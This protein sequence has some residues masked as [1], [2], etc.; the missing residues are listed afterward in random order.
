[1]SI[2]I[3]VLPSTKLLK[4]CYGSTQFHAWNYMLPYDSIHENSLKLLYV[5]VR[6]HARNCVESH[7][8]WIRSFCFPVNKGKRKELILPLFFNLCVAKYRNK[9]R[10]HPLVQSKKVQ[11]SRKVPKKIRVKNTKGGSL[12]CFRGSGRRCFCFGRGFGVSSM[13]WTSV[14]Q[15]DVVEQMNKTVDLTGLKKLPSVI[16]GLIFY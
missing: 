6:F 4:I 13:F 2:H 16:L 5:V 12:V 10:G 7:L 1:M 3:A 15:G 8:G 11:K 9:G 14:V